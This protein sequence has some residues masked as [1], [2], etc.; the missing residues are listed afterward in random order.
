MVQNGLTDEV[1]TALVLVLPVQRTVEESSLGFA[2]VG[3]TVVQLL[4]AVRAEYQTGKHTGFAGFGFTVTLLAD[5][6]NLFKYIFCNDGLRILHSE[7]GCHIC[8]WGTWR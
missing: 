7:H 3:G 2:I 5:L 6:L 4:A 1:C 8:R